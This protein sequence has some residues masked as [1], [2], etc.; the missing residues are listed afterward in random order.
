MRPPEIS[1]N[2][3]SDCAITTGPRKR[4]IWVVP[5]IAGDVAHETQV[6]LRNG[7]LEQYDRRELVRYSPAP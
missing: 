2:V 1:S 5:G 4:T 7:D 3:A 6:R